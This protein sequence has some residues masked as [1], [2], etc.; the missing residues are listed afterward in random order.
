MDTH[1]L[2][3]FIQCIRESTIYRAGYIAEQCGGV[4]RRAGNERIFGGESNLHPFFV[5]EC[6][7][8]VASKNISFITQ[9]THIVRHTEIGFESISAPPHNPNP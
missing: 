6:Y 3:P 2:T 5:K 7:L 4:R 9:T 1:Y 8:C